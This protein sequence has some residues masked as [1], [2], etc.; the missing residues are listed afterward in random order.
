M[1]G[2]DTALAQ[3]T[4]PSLSYH[5]SRGLDSVDSTEHRQAAIFHP[6]AGP[7]Q[8]NTIS[9][10]LPL[11]SQALSSQNPVSAT[12]LDSIRP[13]ATP[14]IFPGPQ[15]L[16]TGC[17]EKSNQTPLV[18][19]SKKRKSDALVK[20]QDQEPRLSMKPKLNHSLGVPEGTC[21]LQPTESDVTEP[22]PKPPQQADKRRLSLLDVF[23]SS[24]ETILNAHNGRDLVV[25][26]SGCDL[27]D[28][29]DG[30]QPKQNSILMLPNDA[31]IGVRHPSLA[32][33]SHTP[34]L[35][36]ACSAEDD[37]TLACRRES[38]E[39]I[40]TAVQGKKKQTVKAS[41]IRQTLT[42][43]A[44]SG[45]MYTP[46][47]VEIG[48]LSRNPR[49]APLTGTQTNLI[50]FDGLEEDGDA[51][52]LTSSECA[53]DDISKAPISTTVVSSNNESSV[54]STS[55]TIRKQQAS[56]L[57]KLQEV[58]RHRSS[59]SGANQTAPQFPQYTTFLHT[60]ELRLLIKSL[61]T[62]RP[63]L[64]VLYG[65]HPGKTTIVR[66]FLSE[67]EQIIKRYNENQVFWVSCSEGFYGIMGSLK[68]V[69][70]QMGVVVSNTPTELVLVDK[71]GS[72]IQ[73]NN[74]GR[75]LIVFDGVEDIQILETLFQRV[76]KFSG[77]VI[78]TMKTQVGV[79]AF[80]RKCPGHTLLL[81]MGR[82]L[83]SDL[84]GLFRAGKGKPIDFSAVNHI[85]EETEGDAVY[86]CLVKSYLDME[87]CTCQDLVQR[88]LVVKAKLYGGVR[89]SSP[90][91]AGADEVKPEGETEAV[92]T[93]SDED[94]L[95]Y[96]IHL[97][98]EAI[99]AHF[100]SMGRTAVCLL[101]VICFTA[102]Y[103]PVSCSFLKESLRLASDNPSVAHAI[104]FLESKGLLR[105]EHSRDGQEN[106]YRVSHPLIHSA[107]LKLETMTPL[108]QIVA[109]MVLVLQDSIPKAKTLLESLDTANQYLESCQ[110]LQ[111]HFSCLPQLLP[112]SGTLLECVCQTLT[113]LATCL[114]Q[115]NQHRD[116]LEALATLISLKQLTTV[117][118][119]N[120]LQQ[121]EVT[122]L[123][124]LVGCIAAHSF[125]VSTANNGP[126]T[127][128]SLNRRNGTKKLYSFVS[129]ILE[130]VT[131]PYLLHN[132]Q[133]TRDFQT[134]IQLA[135]AYTNLASIHGHHAIALSE[136]AAST[137]SSSTSQRGTQPT[138]QPARMFKEY[139]LCA[140]SAF[141]HLH[142]GR[143]SLDVLGVFA[144]LAT[145]CLVDGDQLGAWNAV[146]KIFSVLKGMYGVNEDNCFD[147]ESGEL[148]NDILCQLMQ[149]SM[150]SLLKGLE[151]RDSRA[152]QEKEFCFG[153]ARAK[154]LYRRLL[155]GTGELR[156][157]KCGVWFK[158]FARIYE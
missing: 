82:M 135:R 49:P 148:V 88:M 87:K 34:S 8:T 115:N 101:E 74:A 56:H 157:G 4:T 73:Q 99:L 50:S 83:E 110:H 66:K 133:P 5:Q 9:H 90:V 125:H 136:I 32:P 97:T 147:G 132:H 76:S 42:E 104:S 128:M 123:I 155:M 10:Q 114:L 134:S 92:E 67:R 142:C 77:H 118:T 112:S 121:Q 38:T 79:D 19:S 59:H 139:T 151:S 7:Q 81:P 31:V 116:A 70:R 129:D 95:L 1:T 20:D 11:V 52:E 122:N 37:V 124:D 137:P 13:S 138:Y 22:G 131:I 33:S 35:S 69:L 36:P 15:V 65:H 89:S 16:S 14:V 12:S 156:D 75:Y 3:A 153:V 54:P 106:L 78:V 72:W 60:R 85:L 102:S 57:R 43:I 17:F 26:D 18:T 55:A 144:M 130:T 109:Q 2:T 24:L 93:D 27:D 96:L 21:A 47:A 6:V 146:K 91:S 48:T 100:G 150:E 68:R 141:T 30:A 105:L 80:S 103:R 58:F 63:V 113:T 84:E 62:P 127:L 111:L 64:A 23:G 46:P 86:S 94:P 145:A 152:L 140:L 108:A 44:S 61:L 107:V 126:H 45:D 53:F 98:L 28:G 40:I 51:F 143:A 119:N 39:P 29:N 149:G 158:S 154:M 41:P 25:T 120:P 71:F 117:D